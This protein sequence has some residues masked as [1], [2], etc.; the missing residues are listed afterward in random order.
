MNAVM[1][2][3]EA[4]HGEGQRTPDDFWL[5]IEE[6]EE[7]KTFYIN[8]VIVKGEPRDRKILLPHPA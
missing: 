2:E 4:K 8:V 1:G 5:E 7:H 3:N 6:E